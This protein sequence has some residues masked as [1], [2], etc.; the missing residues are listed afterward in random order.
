MKKCIAE[1]KKQ[2]EQRLE[3]E[4]KAIQENTN[5]DAKLRRTLDLLREKSAGAWLTCLPIQSL[6]YAFNKEDFQDGVRYR[7]N[8]RMP[9]TPSHCS[10]GKENTTDHMMICKLG[11]YV[12]M[13]H[14]RIRDLEAELMR[15]VC[16]DVRVEP[17]LIPIAEDS[18][19]SG[20]TANKARL[21]VSGVGV[22][23]PYEKTYL[24]IRVMHP[25]APS[26]LN[27]SLDQVYEAHEKEKK[28]DYLER[29]IQIEKGSFTPIVMSTHGG[30]GT[31]ANRHHKRIATLIAEKRK[32]SY[33]DVVNYIR[34]RLRVSLMKSV[35]TAIRGV[36][37]K[38]RET[39]APISSLDFNLIE[40][41]EE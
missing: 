5:I 40:H 37:G 23:G 36:R 8:W 4:F 16:H 22:W 38:R 41:T 7:Y 32:E 35:L 9:G 31:E 29:V 26:Y 12:T 3:E 27:K 28:R 39:A 20:N 21:D 34:T 15:E 17:T 24:D 19:R 18:N 1:I 6:G 11:G 33:A 30:C 13:R 10:C 25:N 14:N 2:K